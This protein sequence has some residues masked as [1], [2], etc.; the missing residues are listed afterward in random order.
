[1]E[2]SRESRWEGFLSFCREY[3]DCEVSISRVVVD[4]EQPNLFAVERTFACTNR[5]TGTLGALHSTL[6]CV[7]TAIVFLMNV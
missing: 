7:F 4:A 1:M 2:L 6:D 3:T 5:E